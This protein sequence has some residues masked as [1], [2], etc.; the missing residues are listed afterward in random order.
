[1]EPTR[2][3]DDALVDLLDVLLEKGAVVEADVIITVADV[4][5]VGLKLRAALAGMTTMTEYGIFEGWDVEKR[6]RRR[7]RSPRL[8]APTEGRPESSDGPGVRPEG[9]ERPVSDR[10]A[11][12]TPPARPETESPSSA[13]PAAD[14]PEDEEGEEDGQAD[15]DGGDAPDE[16]PDEEMSGPDHD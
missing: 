3:P 13:R 6:R 14:A 11:D 1:M 4:P 2:D 5:L 12:G 10:P 9:R 7:D 15:P 8:G 16:S